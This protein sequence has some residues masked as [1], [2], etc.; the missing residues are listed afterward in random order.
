MNLE[1]QKSSTLLGPARSS[2]WK[3]CLGVLLLALFSSGL[4]LWVRVPC[5]EKTKWTDTVAH[6]TFSL[7]Q[8]RAHVEEKK[9]LILDARDAAVFQEGHVPGALSLP[10]AD[11]DRVFERLRPQLAGKEDTL[12][13]VYCSDLWCGQ[14]DLLQQKLVNY[15]FQHVGRFPDGW[16]AWSDASLPVEK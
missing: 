6:P 15:G 7:A 4:A 9:L 11:F 14:A 3:D 13:I 12:L 16:A 2:F 8:F 5:G 10:V 1:A